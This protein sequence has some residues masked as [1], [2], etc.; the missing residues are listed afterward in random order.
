M[1][2]RTM[3]LQ[4]DLEFGI[5]PAEAQRDADPLAHSMKSEPTPL[6]EEMEDPTFDLRACTLARMRKPLPPPDTESK[7]RKR[8]MPIRPASS[9]LLNFHELP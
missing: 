7:K 5:G 6:T 3:S 8:L 9:P 1:Q 4:V 2:A